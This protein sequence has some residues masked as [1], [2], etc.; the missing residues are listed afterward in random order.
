MSV[1]ASTVLLWLARSAKHFFAQL[2]KQ[3]ESRSLAEPSAADAER[4]KG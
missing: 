3:V 1:R 4:D 2:E